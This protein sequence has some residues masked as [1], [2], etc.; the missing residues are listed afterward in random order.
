VAELVNFLS[1]PGGPWSY[2][3]RV[4]P[5]RSVEQRFSP[6]YDSVSAARRFLSSH[7]S[8]WGLQTL[9]WPAQL[10]L[11]ELATN[12]VLHAG[13]EFTV[14]MHL[15][16]GRALRLEVGDGSSRLPRP[17]HYEADATTGRGVA[18]VAELG[19]SWGVLQRPG[20]KTVWCE[21][22]ASADDRGVTDEE[23]SYEGA[24]V[25][26]DRWLTPSDTGD[27]TEARLSWPAA[28]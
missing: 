3:F 24:D 9:L 4:P 23:R 18:L 2:P 25:D 27:I 5:L 14:S 22:I 1:S 19:H 21:L 17:R 8:E 12:S 26:L 6:Q 28:A 7:L 15:L 10:I 13:T 16:T 11:S 20:G